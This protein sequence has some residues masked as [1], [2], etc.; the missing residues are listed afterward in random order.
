[1]PRWLPARAPL[2]A[3]PTRRP[4][5]LSFP[6]RSSSSR[7]TSTLKACWGW[8]RWQEVSWQK[9]PGL[10][11]RS[12]TPARVLMHALACFPFF[13]PLSS[14]APAYRYA[15]VAL[16]VPHATLSCLPCRQQQQR[17][18]RRRRRRE[19]CGSPVAGPGCPCFLAHPHDDEGRAHCASGAAFLPVLVW[20]A[21]TSREAPLGPSTWAASC[22]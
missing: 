4:S 14:F 19:D 1:M 12:G 21:S 8:V 11:P 13:A 6:W 7:W 5:S 17:R 18:R 16:G 2:P 22:S 10:P 9:S 3:P 15:D 20:A